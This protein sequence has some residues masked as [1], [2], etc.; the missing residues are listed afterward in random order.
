M[1][2]KEIK[3]E[4]KVE[5]S[6]PPG[7]ETVKLPAAASLNALL[8]E[9]KNSDHRFSEYLFIPKTGKP[10]IG[11]A[12]VNDVSVNWV[13]FEKTTLADGDRVFFILPVSGG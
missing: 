1:T 11:L 9:L 13:N 3:V 12:L 8:Q 4:V 7:Y 10:A 6:Y 5:G 2:E